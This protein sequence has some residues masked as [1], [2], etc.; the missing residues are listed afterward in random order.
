MV[1]EK[2]C[3]LSEYWVNIPREKGNGTNWASSE[4]HLPKKYLQ[5]RLKLA[6]FKQWTQ[7]EAHATVFHQH[8]YQYYR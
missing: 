1:T 6:T 4:E 2:S 7:L 8:R 5:K 3:Q